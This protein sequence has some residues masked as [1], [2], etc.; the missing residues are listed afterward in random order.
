M[1][2]LVPIELDL[3]EEVWEVLEALA[4]KH[5]T[6]VEEYVNRLLTDNIELLTI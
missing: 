5:N 6:S 1:S 2:Y 3:P 4:A